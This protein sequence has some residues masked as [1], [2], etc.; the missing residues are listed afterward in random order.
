M[1]ELMLKFNRCFSPHLAI[2]C[3]VESYSCKMAG[4]DKRLYKQ[5]SHQDSGRGNDCINSNTTTNTTTNTTSS[6]P[7]PALQALSPPLT[8]VGSPLQ[9]VGTS[10]ANRTL[11]PS[12]LVRTVSGSSSQG[13]GSGGEMVQ[14]CDTI[15]NKTLF[16][17]RSTLTSSFQPDYDFTDTKSDEFSRVPSIQWVKY[18][19]REN[20]SAA[21]G[22]KFT[23]FEDQLWIAIDEEINLVECDIY[24]C[25]GLVVIALLLMLFLT[26]KKVILSCVRGIPP[27]IQLYIHTHTVCSLPQFIIGR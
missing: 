1:C 25:R 20:L 17:L 14:L 16:Y 22:E 21:A 3:R 7:T 19:M 24:R 15:S 18:A 6:I 27:H 8:F 12:V 9:S 13:M 5:L 23:A 2:L 11:F 4:N 10:P 26:T